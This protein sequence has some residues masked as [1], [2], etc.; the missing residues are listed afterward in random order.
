MLTSVG[1]ATAVFGAIGSARERVAKIAMLHAGP[2]QCSYGAKQWWQVRRF[3]GG[4][5]LTF[6]LQPGR[7][8]SCPLQERDDARPLVSRHM[9]LCE[10]ASSCRPPWRPADP[11][12]TPVCLCLKLPCAFAWNSAQ[13]YRD[14]CAKASSNTHG[15]GACV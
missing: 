1:A 15:R 3:T 13:A 12:Q 6:V 10:C 7:S 2:Y 8:L 9:E 11:N 4:G 14:S 5:R